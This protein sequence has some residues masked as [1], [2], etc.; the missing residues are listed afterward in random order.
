MVSVWL[1]ACVCVCVCVWRPWG[2]EVVVRSAASVGRPARQAAVERAR[3]SEAWG[4]EK[5]GEIKIEVVFRGRR[6]CGRE[7]A[8][9]AGRGRF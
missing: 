2:G 4:F 7:A 5:K 1:R 9:G 8:A 3:V 6:S